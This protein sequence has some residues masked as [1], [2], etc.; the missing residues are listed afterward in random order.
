MAGL[1]LFSWLC[2]AQCVALFSIAPGPVRAL[3]PLLRRLVYLAAFLPAPLVVGASIS[4]SLPVFLDTG[5]KGLQALSRSRRLVAGNTAAVVCV[6]LFPAVLGA[7]LFALSVRFGFNLC[8]FF[9]AEAV[10]AVF[11]LALLGRLYGAL[12]AARPEA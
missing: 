8:A 4:L 9:A 11:A 5:T 6:E 10:A 2:A 12:A 3:S 1:A 7:A